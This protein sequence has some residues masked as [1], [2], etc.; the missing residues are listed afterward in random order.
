[1]KL[2]RK[3]CNMALSSLV[4]TSPSAPYAAW[5]VL[6]STQNRL[7]DESSEEPEMTE[8]SSLVTGERGG[9]PG[10]AGLNSEQGR[11][12]GMAIDREGGAEADHTQSGIGCPSPL[13]VQQRDS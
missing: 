9:G 6:L 12:M 2:E 5:N 1:M 10:V 13:Q 7:G 11:G 4:H 3:A 8:E